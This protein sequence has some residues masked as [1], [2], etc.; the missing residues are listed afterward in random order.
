[1]DKSLYWSPKRLM[2]YTDCQI[3]I[4]CGA[5][6]LGKTYGFKK[7]FIE[8]YINKGYQ[9]LYLRRY[10]TDY[11]NLELF[12]KDIE[13]DQ[14]F[15]D[16]TFKVEKH[17][18]WIR[19][20]RKKKWEL[21]GFFESISQSKSIK[22]VNY[23]NVYNV[24]F[25]EFQIDTTNKTSNRYIPGELRYFS[26]IIESFIRDRNARIVLASNSIES[27]NPYF[28][29][30]QLSPKKNGFTKKVLKKEIFNPYTNKMET[31][32]LRIAVEMVDNRTEF[33][34]EKSKSVSGLISLF[35]DMGESSLFNEYLNDDDAF[36]H[37][38]PKNPN[39]VCNLTYKGKTYGVWL[40][41]DEVL[42]FCLFIDTNFQ[43]GS[44]HS[45]CFLTSDK[46]EKNI[47]AKSYKQ[48]PDLTKI[49]A[50]V[51]KN[52]CYFVNQHV[53]SACLE[54]FSKLSIY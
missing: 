42:G 1:M 27:S 23:P 24:F 3:H 18:A 8:D 39:F 49:R 13:K 14:V 22:G 41:L 33:T 54:I 40:C 11:N 31:R 53:K 16:Y 7:I 47:Y 50:Y 32:E 15:T 34:S 25:D 35:T 48:L 46:N 10:D 44:K 43:A 21:L 9:F 17:K 37:K 29:C 2:S 38:R 5:R 6:G 45:Y 12:F 4:A 26:D 19:K 51:H 20:K 28:S 52:R 36:I 30:W